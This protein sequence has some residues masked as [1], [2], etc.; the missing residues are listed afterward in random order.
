MSKVELDREEDKPLDPEMEK[1]RRKMVRLLGVSI[2]IMFVGVMAVL[3]GVVYKIVQ[4]GEETAQDLPV[5]SVD[6]SPL[7]ARVQAGLP[8]GFV[9]ESVSL[10]GSRVLFYGRGSDGA[11]KALI[12]DITTGHIVSQ[13]DFQAS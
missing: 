2:A 7:P 6:A 8:V 5:A 13:I 4:P 12:L 11:N 1:V 10:D 3:A 9:V